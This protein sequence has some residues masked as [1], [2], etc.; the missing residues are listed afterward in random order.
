MDVQAFT[1]L[2]FCSA[3]NV[4]RAT[5]YVMK[6]AGEGPRTIKLGR[7]TL[8]SRAAAAEW[9]RAL[10]ARSSQVAS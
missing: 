3:Y 2:Q 1:V 10:E 4:S 6:K 7:R 9:L 8:I 5:F